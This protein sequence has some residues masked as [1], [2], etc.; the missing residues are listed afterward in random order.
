LFKYEKNIHDLVYYY[1]WKRNFNKK[2]KRHLES[3]FNEVVEIWY[4]EAEKIKTSL[5]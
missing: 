5:D 1:R 2:I 3:R 4:E